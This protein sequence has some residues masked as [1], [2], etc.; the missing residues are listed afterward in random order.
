MTGVKGVCGSFAAFWALMSRTLGAL[1]TTRCARPGAWITYAGMRDRLFSWPA[2]VAVA[3]LVAGCSS[4]SDS[5]TP[6]GSV[7]ATSPSVATST[8][9]DPV[10]EPSTPPADPTAALEAEITAFFEEYIAT[11]NAS[12]TSADALARRRQMFSDSCA[13]CLAGYSFAERAHSEQLQ[14]HAD[15]VVLR[16][17]QVTSAEGAHVTA[18]TVEDSPAGVLQGP[19]G[20]VVQEF[21]E[22]LGAQTVYQLVKREDN[23]WL[24]IESEAL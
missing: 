4:D 13:D 7:S 14:L 23:S 15:E 17:I 1:W 10:S 9:T 2:V 5:P 19:D 6:D 16:D 18:L 11:V 20:S 12:W 3:A 21:D 22:Y 8:A 24:I